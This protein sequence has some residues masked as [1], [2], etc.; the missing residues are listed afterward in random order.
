MSKD[1]IYIASLSSKEMLN[2]GIT[3]GTL[4][5]EINKVKEEINRLMDMKEC[6]QKISTVIYAGAGIGDVIQTKKGLRKIVGYHG[7]S[8]FTVVGRKKDGEWSKFEEVV[9]KW[10][11]K[12][13]AKIVTP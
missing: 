8:F 5:E 3:I 12:D 7:V 11:A 9:S 6:M 2:Q 1:Y 10:D 4:E 13:A